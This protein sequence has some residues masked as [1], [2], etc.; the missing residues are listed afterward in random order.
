MFKTFFMAQ[1]HLERHKKIGGKCP[2]G[3]GLKWFKKTH[4]V[5][6]NENYREN[7]FENIIRFM[8]NMM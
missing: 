3:Y 1:Q 6:R 8:G 7:F 5:E 4:Y 2:S